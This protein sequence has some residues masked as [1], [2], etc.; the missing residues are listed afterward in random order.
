MLAAVSASI[1]TVRPTVFAVAA[2]S[3]AEAVCVCPSQLWDKIGT[4][5]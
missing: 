2:Q 5:L 3:M 1:S 4:A